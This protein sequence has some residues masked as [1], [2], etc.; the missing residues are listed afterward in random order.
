M[1]FINETFIVDAFSR[2]KITHTIIVLYEVFINDKFSYRKKFILNG[3]SYRKDHRVLHY[4]SKEHR[5][6][7]FLLRSS[8]F[9]TFLI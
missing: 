9:E 3:F 2:R 8:S 5:L 6:L 7:L 4:L 1:T